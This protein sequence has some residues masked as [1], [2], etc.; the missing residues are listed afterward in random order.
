MFFSDLKMKTKPLAL[1]VDDD[2]SSR[3]TMA[4]ALRKAGFAIEQAAS[5]EMAIALFNEKRPNLIFLDVMM[6][7]MDGF[8]TCREIRSCLGGEYVQIL[9]VT[10]LND[11]ESIEKAFLAGGNDFIAKPINWAMLCHRAH[12]MLRTGK[13]LKEIHLSRSFLAKT[14]DIAKIGNWKVDYQD[15]LCTISAEAAQLLG[16][17][18]G[19]REDLAIATLLDTVVGREKKFE[20]A[21]VEEA[22]RER[23]TFT[24]N[25]Q[26]VFAGRARHIHM[27]GEVLRTETGDP[28]LF[29]GVVHDSTQMKQAEKEI[30]YLAFYDS[31]TGLANRTLL[32]NRLDQVLEHSK[33]NKR[34]FALL[35][36]DID[37][38]KQIN[39]SM[40][41]HAGDILLKNTADV[42]KQCVRRSDVVAAGAG[43]TPD[44]LVARHGGDEFVI[45]LSEIVSSE[46]AAV[47]ARR[48]LQAIPQKQ[49]IDGQEISVTASIGI[50]VFPED[51][52]DADTL[53]RHADTAM[54]HAKKRGNNQYQ[55]FKEALN[56]AAVL[57][58][59]LERD[60]KTALANG[61]FI[62]HFQPQL[63]F[64]DGG[65]LGAEALIR[66]N[67]PQKGFVPPDQFIAIAEDCG[68]IVDIN[69]WVI[70]TACLQ[71]RK[72]RDMGLPAMRIAVNLSG[73]RFGEQNIVKI[74]QDTLT[75][76]A[77]DGDSIEVEVT[78][79]VLM[80]DTEAII[81]TLHGIK[82]LGIKVA[83]DDFGTG[84][85]SLSYLT[86]FHVDT[87]K[88]DR[89]FVMD[90][91]DNKKNRIIIKAI[92]AMGHSLD[93]EIVAEGIESVE[94][95]RLLKKYGCDEY[96]GYYFSPPVSAIKFESLLQ[97]KAL[98]SVKEQK[99]GTR[100]PAP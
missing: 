63:R 66:W 33:R 21:I 31:L 8:Q 49:V 12:Y 7:G 54:Y 23:K 55:F 80:H 77:L 68:L 71:N 50:S 19:Q 51:G 28:E 100:I 30:R 90:C 86:S 16:L 57:R 76:Y 61:D 10:G 22:I 20:Y 48:I 87:I 24:V 89:S 79:N 97:E 69:K 70:E 62:L 11:I 27:H 38:F 93:M 58:F 53:L 6:P 52:R 25:F 91:C 18:P 83:L 34:S 39:D 73:Y 5:G 47:V 14:Q 65:I 96:Q 72:W 56:T 92:I 45:I 74:L 88:I 94:Q 13:A 75:R 46:N 37:H 60:M 98:T 29:L 59:A 2:N 41:H 85:S 95:F 3:M 78:E 4:A 44:N 99:S 17:S 82:D 84:Y 15:N 42:L 9:M 81:E 36:M 40:G 32:L 67:H 64:S 35:F 43:D 1:I 26:I